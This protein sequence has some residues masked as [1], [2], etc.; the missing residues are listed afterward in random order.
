MNTFGQLLRL[1]T[2]GESHGPAITAIVDGFPAGITIDFDA[3][4]ATMDTRRPG[5]GGGG[6]HLVAGGQEGAL[7]LKR[8]MRSGL[9]S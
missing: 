2:A 5:Q 3:L 9:S 6:H 7:W 8:G 4:Q 1:T